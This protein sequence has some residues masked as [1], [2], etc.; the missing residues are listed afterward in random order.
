[1]SSSLYTVYT[2]TQYTVVSTNS[3]DC[4]DRP[5]PEMTWYVSQVGR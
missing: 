3:I 2:Y 4:L 1:M 5:V